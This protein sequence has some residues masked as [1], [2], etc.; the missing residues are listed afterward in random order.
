VTGGLCKATRIRRSQLNL[1]A[2]S[3]TPALPRTEVILEEFQ[4]RDSSSI[5]VVKVTGG[6][7][8]EVR[9]VG[10][11]AE[12]VG[13]DGLDDGYFWTRVTDDAGGIDPFRGPFADL[14]SCEADMRRTLS[15]EPTT[16]IN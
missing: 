14:P 11:F 15:A 1:F 8:R 16:P 5:S 9:G 2:K 4:M 12:S 10:W 3:G 7:M 13:V 6:R